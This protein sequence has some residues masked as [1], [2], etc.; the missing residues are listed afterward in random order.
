MKKRHKPFPNTMPDEFHGFYL[1]I[2]N[3]PGISGVL[4]L[5]GRAWLRPAKRWWQFWRW[6]IELVETACSLCG[7]RYVGAP[8]GGE[9][10]MDF[11]PRQE[12]PSGKP[13]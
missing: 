5:N 3:M 9:M 10:K 12:K 8:G 13:H 7:S 6:D 2:P 4:F 1:A 11:N